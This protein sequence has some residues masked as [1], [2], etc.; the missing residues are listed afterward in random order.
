MSRIMYNKEVIDKE[1][2]EI[3]ISFLALSEL[4]SKTLPERIEAN[5]LPNIKAI[6]KK[7]NRR[8]DSFIC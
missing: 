3:I 8:N 6:V 7:A 5:P 1:M 2:K 4:I